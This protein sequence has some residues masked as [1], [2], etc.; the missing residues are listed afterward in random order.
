[1]L[2]LLLELMTA[3][4]GVNNTLESSLS[5]LPLGE[6]TNL[7]NQIANLDDQISNAFQVYTDNYDIYR[8][9]NFSGKKNPN[10]ATKS[11]GLVKTLSKKYSQ[12]YDCLG[13]KYISPKKL[14]LLIVLGRILVY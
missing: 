4:D 6:V 3:L 10:F 7:K 5:S 9:V 1:M 12:R 8:S 2:L 13:T 11:E 14:M